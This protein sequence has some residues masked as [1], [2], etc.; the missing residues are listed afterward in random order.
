MTFLATS[1]SV[2]TGRTCARGMTQGRALV[3]AGNVRGSSFHHPCTLLGLRRSPR[4]CADTVGTKLF[5]EGLAESNDLILARGR[6][7]SK[8]HRSHVP[9]VIIGRTAHADRDSVPWGLRVTGWT[10]VLTVGRPASI[11]W[12]VTPSLMIRLD[13][14]VCAFVKP[15][16]LMNVIVA[17]RVGTPIPTRCYI[18]AIDASLC[19]SVPT[20]A[21]EDTRSL[22][23]QD[24]VL[25]TARE[26]NEGLAERE[27]AAAGMRGGSRAH[28]CFRGCAPRPGFTYRTSLGE[29]T[30]QRRVRI[31]RRTG[32]RRGDRRMAVEETRLPYALTWMTERTL[33][34]ALPVRTRSCTTRTVPPWKRAAELCRE[35]EGEPL[36][37]G[38]L[39]ASPTAGQFEGRGWGLG[40]DRMTTV[41]GLRR[42]STRGTPTSLVP[43]LT[44]R[45]G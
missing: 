9:Y 39:A 43:S 45:R 41:R 26:A 19:D 8:G 42:D 18:D 17:P 22:A 25:G 14:I 1:C 35:F 4:L 15:L 27:V 24:L 3:R 44:T 29:W 37:L 32:R 30:D 40:C 12:Q 34:A 33:V 5:T 31:A 20:A 7:G 36:R 13:W 28:G 21:R 10:R 23:A 11:P 6:M 2:P 16:L 38:A